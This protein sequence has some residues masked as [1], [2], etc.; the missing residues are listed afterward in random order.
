MADTLS[1]TAKVE[2]EN[3]KW[4]S[5]SQVSI[6]KHVSYPQLT[7]TICKHTFETIG[8]MAKKLS[9]RFLKDGLATELLR[10][11]CK[12]DLFMLMKL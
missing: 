4:Y 1:F 6:A 3:M 7:A 5:P 2:M 10:V 8:H 12:E 9:V 11:M